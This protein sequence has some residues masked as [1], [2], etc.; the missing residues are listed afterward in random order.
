MYMYQP[1]YLNIV[2]NEKSSCKGN[3]AIYVHLKQ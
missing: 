2:M 3:S 1:R